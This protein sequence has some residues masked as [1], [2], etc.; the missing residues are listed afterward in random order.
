MAESNDV[1]NEFL[2]YR[3]ERILASGSDAM[4]ER[5]LRSRGGVVTRAVKQPEVESREMPLEPFPT[6][7]KPPE[8]QSTAGKIMRNVAEVPKAA[9][10]GVDSAI[11]N[12]TDW[13]IN[14]LVTW[15]NENVADLTFEVENPQTHTGKV[16]KSVSEFLTGYI[17]ALKYLKALGMAGKVGSTLTAAAI[18]DFA[19]KDPHEARLSNL[20]K[21]A[22]LPANMLT[23]YLAA[24]PSDNAI[25][26]RFKSAVES[27]FT[28]AAA[29]GIVLGARALRAAK[30]VKTNEQAELAALK[31]RYGEL[32]DETFAKTI[33]DPDKPMIETVVKKP[34]AAGAKVRRG[35]AETGGMT[36]DDLI[37]GYG[38]VDAGEMSLRINFS[39]MASP[40]D[41]KAVIADMSERFKGTVDEARRGKIT[42]EETAK[43]ADDL[44]MSVTD[45]LERTKGQA[46]NAEQIVAARKLW[47]ASGE[48]LLESARAAAAPNAGP[49]D[50]Y[51]FRKMLATH[52]AIQAEVLGMRAEAGRA[53]Q[54]WKI[55]AGGNLEKARSVD[56]MLAAMGGAP[57]AQELARRLAIL[58]EHG[59][60][61]ALAKF[62]E[63]ASTASSMDVVREV[64]INGLLSSPATHAVNTLSNTAVA[65]QAMLE[66]GVA[67]QIGQ[68]RGATDSVAPGEAMAMAYGLVTSMKDA[69]RIAAK[70]F[71]TG[72]TG[73]A[74]NK[75]DLPNRKALAAETFGISSETG[76]GR[77]IDFVGEAARVPS[78]FL[79]AEDEF[80]KTIGYRM[81]LHAH[82][83]RQATSEGL[84]GKELAKRMREI[85]LDP[86][87]HV[88]IASADVAL[89]QTFTNAPGAIGQAF[90]GLRERVP[91]ISFVLPF[92][93]T[94]VNIARYTFERTPFAPLVAQWRDDIAA[95]GARADLALARM[96]TG[97]GVMLM[98]LD[99]A[100]SGLISGSGPKEAG[101]RE[102]MTRQGWQPY[103]IKVGDRWM[104]FNRT[105]P[106]GAMLGFAADSA[107]AIRRGEINEDDVDEWQEVM[108]MGI[109]AVSQV[110]IN[111]T[112]L[113]GV[114]EF[115][116]MMSD[117]TRYS[118]SYVNK[119][120]ASFLPFTSLF[121]AVERAADPVVREASTPWQA[122][123]AKLTGLSEEL[124]PRLNLWGEEI[125]AE[126]GLGK[127]YD[128]FSPVQSREVKPDPVDTEIMRLAPMAAKDNVAGAA[129]TR[130]GKRTHFDGVQVNFKEYPDEYTEYVRLAGNDLKHPAWGMGAKDFLN[131]VITGGHPMSR[132]YDMR[133]DEM[134]LAFIKETISQYRKLAQ[135]AILN[136][137]RFEDFTAHVRAIQ[138]EK[139]KARMPILQ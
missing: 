34:S 44:G 21:E 134:K 35:A 119:L 114:A 30:S 99:W 135:Q 74:L 94:P 109:T 116:E 11:R 8:E 112:Y 138:L 79:G 38:I 139:Q 132:V 124:P 71:A 83:L 126:S 53:L 36:P 81:E 106:F 137:K 24:D 86:P 45:L 52:H 39:R 70:S 102:A 57:Q 128:F 127:A 59:D 87:E 69:F 63:K 50:Q 108:A 111:K 26:G 14:P 93:R 37:G 117:P 56:Q 65:F 113:Q 125:T 54:A 40:D 121:G 101:E 9:A 104:S 129:P 48:R 64:W 42:N 66:R 123:K 27:V 67:S 105:D 49:L 80:F 7:K 118:E 73:F 91:A 46:Y 28:G 130:I 68:L 92:V 75:V 32:S 120:V 58:A 107:E 5:V 76:M 90:M 84:Q 78:R 95:G 12:A 15:L 133:S 82:A 122:I 136:D 85:I 88:R 51:A 103:S 97:T 55:P 22:G 96:S 29:E 1:S 72:E 61:G 13:A 20:W 25:E 31:E 98:A 115:V 47:A 3:D 19:T 110:A 62:A 60:K 4:I 89:Y 41:V 131:T 77:A 18:A 43:M 16:A 100:D 33:G 2:A 17:P 23:N 10:L 6:D